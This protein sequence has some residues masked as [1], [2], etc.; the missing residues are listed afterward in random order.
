MALPPRHALG[1]VLLEAGRA[2]EAETVYW[3]DLKRNPENGWALLGLG[4]ALAAQGR[5]EPSWCAGASRRRGRAR[6]S[7]RA[8]GGC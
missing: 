6:T 4:Q 1:A 5:T 8:S 2:R 7:S 3:E